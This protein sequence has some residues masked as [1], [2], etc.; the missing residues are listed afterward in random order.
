MTRKDDIVT[1][2]GVPR[3]D[4]PTRAGATILGI[5]FECIGHRVRI[6]SDLGPAAIREQSCLLR[7]YQPPHAD[8]DPLDRLNVVDCGDIDIAAG[9]VAVAYDSI[10]AAVER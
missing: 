6:G 3:A 4:K 7:P 9:D 5:P 1:F 2:M 8:F 10:T